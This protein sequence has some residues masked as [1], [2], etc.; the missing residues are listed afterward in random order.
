MFFMKKCTLLLLVISFLFFKN[1][2]AQYYDSGQDPFSVN[3]FQI[4]T[5]QFQLIYPKELTSRA[6]LFANYLYTLYNSPSPTLKVQG[7]NLPVILHNRT[8]FSNGEVAWAPRRMNLFAISPQDNEYQP[9]E[10]HLVTHEFRHVLQISRTNQSATKVLTSFFG[11]HAVTGIM[12]LFVPFWFLEGDAV[13]FETGVANAGRGRLPDFSM[14]LTAQV[15]EKG[16]YSYPKAVFGS[17]RDYVPDRYELGYQL[18]AH[19]RD[20]YGATC[21]DQVLN[22]VATSPFS[23]NPFSKG[24]KNVTGLSERDW[25]KQVLNTMLTDSC[26]KHQ[27]SSVKP[28]SVFGFGSDY[29]NYYNPE[30]YNGGLIAYKTS[31][32]RIPSFVYI[33]KEGLE[34]ILFKP[35]Y[36]LN[37]TYS[38]N[39][40][41]LVWN[42]LKYS[43]W[44][45]KN[46]SRVA[47]FRLD[48]NKLRYLHIGKQVYATQ[49][50]ST[51][52]KMVSAETSN[53]IDWMLVIRTIKGKE[54]LTFSFDTLQPVQPSWSPNEDKIV[55]VAIGRYGKS[56]G[57]L[58][59]ESGK[60]NWILENQLIDL[61]YP[62]YSE[63]RIIVK[64]VFKQK[65]N[66][67]QFDLQTQQWQVLTNEPFGVD[68][69]SRKSDSLVFSTYTS[70]GFQIRTLNLV[71]HPGTQIEKPEENYSALADCL[72]NQ[73]VNIDF[74][75]SDS[76]FEQKKYSRLA[77]LFRFHS[78]FPL[79]ID[80]DNMAVGPGV[81]VMSQNAL[82]T[83][84][85]NAGVQYYTAEQRPEYFLS[86]A[87]KG[88][89]PEL[90]VRYSFSPYSFYSERY[91]NNYNYDLHELQLLTTFPFVFDRASW[92]RRID[93]QLGYNYTAALFEQ[94]LNYNDMVMHS[95]VS[96]IYI[97]NIQRTS[98]RDIYPRWGQSLYAQYQIAPFN[99]NGYL[100]AI[101]GW[102]Y[103]PGILLN[104]SFRISGGYQE[105]EDGTF[106]F[107]DKIVYPRGYLKTDNNTMA[108]LRTDYTLPIMYPDVELAHFMYIQRLR[109]NVFSDNAWFDDQGTNI[110]QQSVGIE[111]IADWY[112]R[113]FVAPI[114]MGVRYA[115]KTT[116][117]QNYFGLLFQVNFSA[118][119]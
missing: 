90:S 54:L 32:K 97:R 51:G 98:K 21:W 40:Q 4:K 58:D 86:Y 28:T 80:I 60:I 106:G 19:M 92:Y 76:V 87:Y 18:V 2:N 109:A 49:I 94:N 82:S 31:Y 53:N 56:L 14:S 75:S 38:F 81:S 50:S 88:F 9:W 73:E 25:Y 101:Q 36:L 61:Q 96:S 79:A 23:F 52:Q 27:S 115:Y 83:S 15:A 102:N 42:E 69:A 16:I 65:S 68:Q 29:V 3:W 20:A 12:G 34:K 41:L 62:K 78:W 108:V 63:N 46:R 110:T 59:V 103:F 107:T 72:S 74:S 10:Q 91:R 17:Y 24:I 119:Y 66:I 77:H 64:G 8:A 35:G 114:Q 11:E 44:D 99:D 48:K 113:R 89:Y 7:A 47:V 26:A 67:Y 6:Q 111:L 116:L 105:K 95:L 30:C 37:N 84:F 85:L 117:N 71:E 5:T 1:I 39:Q 43:R 22:K 100:Y 55:F 45:N 118:L 70:N 33:N 13:A 93:I 112:F 57:E 104:H